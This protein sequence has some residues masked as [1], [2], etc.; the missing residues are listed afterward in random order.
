MVAVAHWLAIHTPEDALIAVHDIGAVGY[1]SHR[2]LLDL[3]GLISPE[4]I[5]FIRDEEQLAAYLDE[6]G[7]SYLVT[8]PEWY[9]GLIQRGEMVF[10][11]TG[12]MSPSLG[13]EN[14]AVYHWGWP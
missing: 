12:K 14:M 10:Q 5:P 6:K 11:T 8:F 7:A 2:E 9:P 3:A 4:V 1:Y 13:G